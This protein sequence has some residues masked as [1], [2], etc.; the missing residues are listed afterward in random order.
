VFRNRRSVA[1]PS[2]DVDIDRPGGAHRPVELAVNRDVLDDVPPAA[3]VS[4][5]VLGVI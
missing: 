2:D 5:E 4:V 3:Q 1:A